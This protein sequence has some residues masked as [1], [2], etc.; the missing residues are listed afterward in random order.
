MR[1]SVWL[2]P[3]PDVPE[4]MPSTFAAKARGFGGLVTSLI[5]PPIDPAP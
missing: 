2:N 4:P 5:V 3:P 1:F